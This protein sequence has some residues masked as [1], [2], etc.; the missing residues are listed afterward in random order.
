MSDLLLFVEIKTN[1]WVDIFVKIV[2]SRKN[3]KNELVIL[4]CLMLDSREAMEA[5]VAVV[6][7]VPCILCRLSK[8]FRP[9][10]L[11]TKVTL[12]HLPSS[13][14][15]PKNA[16]DCDSGGLWAC[17]VFYS[18]FSEKVFSKWAGWL[19][20]EIG[21]ILIQLQINSPVQNIQHGTTIY[22]WTR[23]VCSIWTTD[24]NVPGLPV[25]KMQDQILR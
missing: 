7:S 11:V 18:V 8:P 24:G 5:V 22:V 3:G 2:K 4:A 14:S 25:N 9:M 6:T 21:M 19:S 16:F 13:L 17:I 20:D 1:T 15:N 23:T 10:T 12:T